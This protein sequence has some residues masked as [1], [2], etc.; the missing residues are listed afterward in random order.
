VVAVVMTGALV[1]GLAT[2]V[3]ATTPTNTT[4]AAVVPQSPVNYGTVVNFVAQVT[5]GLGLKRAGNPTVGIP[6]GTLTFSVGALKLCSATLVPSHSGPVGHL[7]DFGEAACSSTTAPVGD[8]AVTASYAGNSTYSPSSATTKLVVDSRGTTTT[9][10][11]SPSVA[12]V[13]TE[14]TYHATV[15]GAGS[16]PTGSVT[17]TV[18]GVSGDSAGTFSET[19]KQCSH[20]LS[21]GSAS[22]PASAPG[23][24]GTTVEIVD[25][26]DDVTATYVPTGVA[27]LGSSGRATLD[28]VQ[29]NGGNGDLDGSTLNAVS[30]ATAKFCVVV[31]NNGDEVTYANGHWSGPRGVD[32]NTPGY[33]L[34][35]VSCPTAQF[36]AA[37]GADGD[38]G[39]G[40]VVMYNG[41][42]WSSPQ[43]I[44]PSP[45]SPDGFIGLVAISCASSTFCMAADAY[46]NAY[47][48]NGSSWSGPTS[49]D[50]FPSSDALAALSCTKP[51]H[52][53]AVTYDGNVGFRTGTGSGIWLPPL[54]GGVSR[55][56]SVSCSTPN[57]CTAVGDGT[58][59]GTP[60]A[61][62][63]WPGGSVHHTSQR[64]S[65]VS[66][67]STTFCVAVGDDWDHVENLGNPFELTYV[68][69]SW[70]GSTPIG[71]DAP[72]L[73]AISC[74]S[75]LFCMA[76]GDQQVITWS[77]ASAP[78]SS[79]PSSGGQPGST[80]SCPACGAN[81]IENPGA[82][83]G[84]G[85]DSNNS[86]P[87]P[88]W[89][90]TGAF[91]AVQYAWSGGDYSAKTP[92]PP[93]PGKN[94]FSGG[95]E[96]ATST[97]S[98]TIA[99]AAGALSG[100]K[101]TYTLSAWLGGYSVWSD[102]ATLSA[103][104]QTATG[105]N[106][107]TVQIGPVTPT[108]RN[109]DTELKHV[110]SSGAV[111]VGTRQVVI[112]LV[113]HASSSGYNGGAADN[114][115]LVLS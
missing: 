21:N 50:L 90:V 61:I 76:V 69:S 52:C 113:F 43:T 6:G 98:Q 70:S 97:G 68:G 104:F 94:Y 81:L 115:S 89:K 74:P 29:F 77:G 38:D 73:T 18:T 72:D 53:T 19:T 23:S 9:V 101:I 112:R 25:A 36:C 15:T 26:P 40:S 41:S 24:H 84:P 22:C 49:L 4:T 47:Y 46:G 109:D 83:A 30:C 5:S 17:F 8:D 66:C 2:P 34:T 51:D 27:H 87:V 102:N 67:A 31:D 7:L 60:G 64:L 111:P 20:A 63:T 110:S 62:A 54:G 55:L 103:Q 16:E 91:T 39:S 42:S 33:G 57:A 80:S 37:V 44:A 108:D 107:A 14:V 32:P 96:S 48:Y 56:S 92:G 99:V 114:L 78:P 59:N 65:A 13:G 11:V 105:A 10:T 75:T 88:D 3:S 58:G 85:A 93:S 71:A 82:E 35:A 79:P 45:P 86:V 28:V 1:L 100:G 95:W 106:L 12:A